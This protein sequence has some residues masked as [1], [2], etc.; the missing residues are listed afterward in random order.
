MHPVTFYDAQLMRC[1]SVSNRSNF[2]ANDDE[3]YSTLMEFAND[4][5]C[6]TRL[7]IL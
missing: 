2:A 6:T 3:Q 7:T 4:G 5:K 1:Y